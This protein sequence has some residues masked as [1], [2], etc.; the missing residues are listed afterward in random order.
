VR[1]AGGARRVEHILKLSQYCIGLHIFASALRL[2]S[3]RKA[4]CDEGSLQPSMRDTGP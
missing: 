4:T 2:F 3:G 1:P